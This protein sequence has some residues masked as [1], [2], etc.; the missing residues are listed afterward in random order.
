M[1]G[2]ALMLP[3]LALT[4]TP[5]ERDSERQ[6]NNDHPDTVV[7]HVAGSKVATAGADAVA[8]TPPATPLNR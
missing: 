5:K 6:P 3:S 7:I 4:M 2:F 8:V 1:V